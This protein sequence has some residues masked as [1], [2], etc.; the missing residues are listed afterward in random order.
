MCREMGMAQSGMCREITEMVMVD[1]P[2]EL[3]MCKEE[4]IMVLGLDQ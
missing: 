1:Q 3:D 4:V 2:V